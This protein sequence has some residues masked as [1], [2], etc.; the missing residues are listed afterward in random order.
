KATADH[1]AATTDADGRFT[2]AGIG[3]DRCPQLTISAKGLASQVCLVPIRPDFKPAPGALTGSPVLGPEFTLPLAPAKPVS[4]VVRDPP[5]KPLAGVHVRGQAELGDSALNSWLVVPDVEALTDAEGK[6]TLDG[7]AK[8]K[9]Y[10]LVADPPPG[11]GTTRRFVTL[12]D[13]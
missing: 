10:H 4:G 6:Y 1:F 2:L 5:K 8:A 11:D 9:K 13:E 7:L 12:T 3:R